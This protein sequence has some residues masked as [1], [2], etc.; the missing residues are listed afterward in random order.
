MEC[1]ERLVWKKYSLDEIK[2]IQIEPPSAQIRQYAR[3][4]WDRVAKPVDGL[5]TFETAIASIG[6]I[7]ATE[8]V[9]I[10]KRAVLIFCADN[11]VVAE[12]ISQSGQEVTAIVAGKMADMKSSVGKMAG[13][14]GMDTIPVDIGIHCEEEIPGVLNRK[15]RSGTRNFAV[16]PA[17]TEEETVRAITVGIDLVRSCKCDGYQIL[18]TGEM[19]IGNT[20]TSSALTAAL[21]GCSAKEV[22]GRGAGLN[23]ARLTKK[24]QII[25]DAL[26]RYHLTDNENDRKK[27]KDTDASDMERDHAFRALMSVGG[28]D[29]AGLVGVCIG[30]ALY[31]VPIVLDGVISLAAA[32]TAERLVPGC[33]EFLLASHIGKEPAAKRLLKELE[34]D[35]VIDARLALGEGTG[36]VMMMGLLDM[37][38]AVYHTETTFSDMNIKQYERYQKS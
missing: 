14:I 15:I 17:M 13:M 19:G 6:A 23:D 30:G 12:G 32:L 9:R 24:I 8:F 20:T 35:A 29:L 34:L 26:E 31:H 36:A 28:L 21:L 16:E 27:Q 5:G 3:D 25:Q 18:A 22:T 7:T 1:S 38:L 10:S 37:A 2:K 33:R 11:G 4:H